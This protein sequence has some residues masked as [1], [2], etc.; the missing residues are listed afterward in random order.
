MLGE[1]ALP[2]GGSAWTSA[3]LEA[4]AAMG[5]EEKTARQAVARSADAGLLSGQRRGRRARWQLTPDASRLLQE[6]TERIYSFG[7]AERDWDGRWLL[8]LT[9]I[10]ETSRH[11]RYRL[12]RRLG[13]AGFAP[14]GPGDW[15]S[16]WVA[17][18][19]EALAV[20]AELGLADRSRSFVGQLGSL[21]DPRALVSE[22]WELE[23]LE[24]DYQAFITEHRDRDPGPGVDAFRAATLLVHEWRHF[25]NAD[26]G[27]PGSLLPERWNGKAAAELFHHLHS[28][29]A[30]LARQWWDEKNTG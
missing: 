7:R 28:R 16:P 12:R 11:L 30:P 1:W 5:V 8:L 6:G 18:E 10:P 15:L 27:L 2:S 26:P 25:P 23:R 20:L 17:R 19:G 4:L 14:I 13:W 24:Q 21:G 29:W 9:S 3:L 22:A